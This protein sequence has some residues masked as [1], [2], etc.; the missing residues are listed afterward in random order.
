MES[1]QSDSGRS[2]KSDTSIFAKVEEPVT[3]DHVKTM[4]RAS[5]RMLCQLR[6]NN[7]IR[8]GQYQIR[9][10]DSGTI[11]MSISEEQNAYADSI[12]RQEEEEGNASLETRTINY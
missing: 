11:L 5:D 4:T 6:D 8:F 10:Y 2:Y 9:D 3:P 12:A 7:L 1:T